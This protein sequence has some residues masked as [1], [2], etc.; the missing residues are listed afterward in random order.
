[1]DHPQSRSRHGLQERLVAQC[2]AIAI[3]A[4][5]TRHL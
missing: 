4:W 2:R 3:N 5:V 1:V